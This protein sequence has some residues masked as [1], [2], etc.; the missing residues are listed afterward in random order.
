MKTDSGLFLKKLNQSIDPLLQLDQKYSELYKELLEA[1]KI[2]CETEYPE[3]VKELGLDVSMHSVEVLKLARTISF[4]HG[5]DRLFIATT[6]DDIEGRQICESFGATLK[7]I[8]TTTP[9]GVAPDKHSIQE[10]CIWEWK[11]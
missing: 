11:F 8:Q 3:A 10:K 5:Y 1:E 7:T 2:F 4:A 9:D 6:P